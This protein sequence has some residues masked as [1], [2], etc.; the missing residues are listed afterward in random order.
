MILINS[1]LRFFFLPRFPAGGPWL[2]FFMLGASLAAV[3]HAQPPGGRGA[4]A[5]NPRLSAPIDLTGYWVSIVSEDWRFR[6]FTPPKGDTFGVPLNAEGTNL[7]N[8]WDPAKDEAAGE[9]FKSY[10]MPAIMRVPGRFHIT[11]QDDNTLKIE[12]DAGR[13][14]RLLHF[15]DPPARLGS[16]S[17][18]GYSSASWLRVAARSRGG[19]GQPGAAGSGG[20]SLKVTTTNLR[21]GYL[22]KNG[23]P[24]SDKTTVTE[25]YDI[26]HE[27]GGADWVVVKTIV[28]DPAY[29]TEPFITSTNL[30]KQSDSSGWNPTACAAR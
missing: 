16:P 5:A 11:W 9:Q 1:W 27:P 25:F 30:R 17:L 20:G 22:R 21:P 28:N 10:G 14:T 7:A 12:T 19:E 15:G 8:A 26:V 23:V 29:L 3:L 24:Y 6:M 4:S 13:Q 2:R 18:Q